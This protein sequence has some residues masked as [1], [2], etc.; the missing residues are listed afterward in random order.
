MLTQG[1][2]LKKEYIESFRQGALIRWKTEL[3]NRLIPENYQAV[4]DM[5]RL[6]NPDTCTDC[7]LAM[8]HKIQSLRAKLAKDSFEEKSVFTTIRQAIAAGDYDTAS[9]MKLEMGKIMEELKVLYHDY[10]QNIID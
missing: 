6:H 7:D 3:L 10:K 9:A 8:W 2:I 4:V 1:D 5:K